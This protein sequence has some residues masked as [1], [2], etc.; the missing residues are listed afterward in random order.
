M[1]TEFQS[2]VASYTKIKEGSLRRLFSYLL[3]KRFAEFEKEYQQIVLLHTSYHDQKENAYHMLFL[4]MSIYLDDRYTIRSNIE[5]GLGRADIIFTA[6]D[7]K[8]PNL[9][10]EFKQGDDVEKL[11]EMALAQIHQKK[12]YAGLTGETLLLGVAHSG[13]EVKILSEILPL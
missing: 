8:F 5:A 11:A 3:S 7:K 13:K 12:Y 1:K 10:I 4:G 6:K 2:I 9:I